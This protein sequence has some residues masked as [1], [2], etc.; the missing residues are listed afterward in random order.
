MGT[1][2]LRKI[3]F[4][5]ES[6]AGSAVAATQMW[7][8]MGVISDDREVIFP[9]EDVGLI[10]GTDRSYIPR[11]MASITFEETP[12]TFELL[13]YI[14]EG[15]I[16]EIGSGTACGDGSVVG[17][18]KYV[19]SFP[20]D[21]LNTLKTFTIEAGDD[22]QAQEMEYSFVQN[23][24]LS[25]SAGEAW[26]VSA[27][28]VGRQAT[29]ASFTGALSIPSVEE[30]LFSKTKLYIDAVGGTIGTTQVSDTLLDATLNV[31]TGWIPKFTAEGDLYFSFAKST[32]PEITLDVTFEF[33][34]TA[35]TERGY[36][37]GETARLVRLQADGAALSTGTATTTTTTYSFANKGM[38]LDLAGK[39]ERFDAIGE[40]DGNDIIS[41]SLRVRYNETATQFADLVICNTASS[42]T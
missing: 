35:V 26:M 8:G 41:A 39:W 34:S 37:E 23:F 4:G 13:P 7:R 28:W 38:I 20:T 42:L 12:A 14:G 33:N 2:A 32:E 19:Y 27:D 9:E 16:K 1:K 5:Q 18:Y 24:S 36:W 31:N 29:D 17:A 25:G 15:G 21:S 40:Q 10:S 6:T 11:V 30:I 3:Q 22:V